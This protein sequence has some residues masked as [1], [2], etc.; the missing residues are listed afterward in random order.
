MGLCSRELI[1][2]LEN[3]FKTNMIIFDILKELKKKIS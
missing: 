1:E 2:N 3:N